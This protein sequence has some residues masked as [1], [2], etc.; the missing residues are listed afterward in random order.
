MVGF[1]SMINWSPW[2]GPSIGI[3]DEANNRNVYINTTN[4]FILLGLQVSI[5][6]KI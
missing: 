3:A 2:I 1:K 5:I 4:I 6:Q